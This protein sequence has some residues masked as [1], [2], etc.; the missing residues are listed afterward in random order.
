M[1]EPEP[2]PA[3]TPAV[4]TKIVE[5]TSDKLNVRVGDAQKYDSVG[6]VQKGDKF[7]WVATSPTTGWHAVRMEKRIGWVSPNYSK[8]VVV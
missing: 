5:I 7:E 2:A 1:A 6:Y 4:G 3:P 8:V